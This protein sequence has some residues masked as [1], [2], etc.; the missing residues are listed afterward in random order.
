MRVGTDA[1]LFDAT[2]TLAVASGSRTTSV[3][4]A[5]AE[6]PTVHVRLE[7]RGGVCTVAF[8]AGIVRVPAQVQRHNTDDRPLAAHYYAFDYRP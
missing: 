3:R 8:V 7:P 1:Q 2:Q 4:I 5:P 6:Q